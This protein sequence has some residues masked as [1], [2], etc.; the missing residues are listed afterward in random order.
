MSLAACPQP[1]IRLGFVAPWSE[2][3]AKMARVRL[4]LGALGKRNGLPQIKSSLTGWLSQEL[5]QVVG[6]HSQPGFLT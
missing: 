4:K 3:G 2:L 6:V 1:S 5:A